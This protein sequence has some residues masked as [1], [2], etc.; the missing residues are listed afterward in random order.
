MKIFGSKQEEITH[1]CRKTHDEDFHILHCSISIVKITKQRRTIWTGNAARVG[2]QKNAYEVR[3]R[4]K[5]II[6]LGISK[7]AW[8]YITRIIKKLK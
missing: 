6:L 4:K 1:G 2:K 8:D 3:I 5:Y 7:N